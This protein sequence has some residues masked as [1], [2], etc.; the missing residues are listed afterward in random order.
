VSY[1]QKLEEEAASGQ[2]KAVRNLVIDPLFKSAKIKVDLLHQNGVEH[3]KLAKVRE[4]C[5]A[6]FKHNNKAKIILFTQFRDTATSLK[7]TLTGVPGVLP[8]IFVGQAKKNG[9]GLSQKQ[10]AEMLAQF[11][12][13]MFN[14][15]IATCVAEE[16]LDIPSVDLVIFYEPVPSAIRTIQ[17]R[18][19]TGRHDTG[20]VVML[21]TKATRDE[22]YANVARN[23][24]K[25]MGTVL[26]DL[27][28]QLNRKLLQQPQAT[29]T[30]FEGKAA[31][32]KSSKPP[33]A[34]YVDYREKASA[35]VK[36]LLE[37]NANVQ[38]EMLSV[39]DYVC[40]G[41]CGIEFKQ[42]QDFVDSILDGRL[43]EQL[44]EL[45]RAYERPV[46]IV[47]GDKDIYSLRNVH[48]NAIRGMIAAITVAFGV[49]LVFSKNAAETAQLLMVM[50]EREQNE[51]SAAFSPHASRK[52]GTTSHQQEYV[53]SSLPNVGPV[54]AKEL[55]KQFGTIKGV[56]NAPPDEL[57][58][59]EGVGEKKA[60][61]ISDFVNAK[62]ETP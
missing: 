48:P 36:E 12:D 32:A 9:M 46:I 57:Q 47:E 28:S 4:L 58:K 26:T 54:L 61:T 27:R 44:R 5:E 6:E 3:P 38:L 43:L 7:K 29:L 35:V 39:G 23:K 8:E 17:R 16:G 62:H 30:R 50:A 53:V 59:V 11:T 51:G 42:Q 56:V 37:R 13:G 2:S 10:Q 18:G 40:S 31:T 55:L 15:L 45:K 34:I 14:V 49:P 19:R 41:R 24:E 60:K 21:I 20:R 25:N 1:L 52:P 22:A 33:A